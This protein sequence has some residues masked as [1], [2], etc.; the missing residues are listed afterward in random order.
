MCYVTKINKFISF[1]NSALISIAIRW[2]TGNTEN[3]FSSSSIIAIGRSGHTKND[4]KVFEKIKN[5]R[6]S[7]RGM[8][9]NE[10]G[11]KQ[12]TIL[13]GI[14][15]GNFCHYSVETKKKHTNKKNTHT[16]KQITRVPLRNYVP[17]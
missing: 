17:S 1:S 8:S 13:R 12:N 4:R 9:R 3:F 6:Q 11:F 15:V 7:C 14:A 2:H 5:Y 16:H 10:T